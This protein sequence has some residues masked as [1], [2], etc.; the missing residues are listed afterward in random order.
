M[1]T[2]RLRVVTWLAPNLRI[3]L[4]QS[5]TQ[6]QVSNPVWF[7]TML[8]PRRGPFTICKTS[9]AVGKSVRLP[10]PEAETG[11]IPLL[12]SYTQRNADVWFYS[13]P[14]PFWNPWCESSYLQWTSVWG[15]RYMCGYRKNSA[16][17]HLV[18][19]FGPIILSS[20]LC[21]ALGN[22]YSTEGMLKSFNRK[23]SHCQKKTVGELQY[24]NS[25]TLLHFYLYRGP[26]I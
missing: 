12:T 14:C 22:S 15:Q 1:R 18:L 13:P 10:R 11:G 17:L 26:S 3:W 2:L 16:M 21:I 25:K 19:S 24:S 8:S 9:Y 4:W 23:A 20:P 6:P 7:S 5:T